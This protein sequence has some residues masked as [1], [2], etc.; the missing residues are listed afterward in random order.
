MCTER[1]VSCSAGFNN[2][3]LLCLRKK[4]NKSTHQPIRKQTN[5][6]NKQTKEPNKNPTNHPKNEPNQQTNQPSHAP[7]IEGK[8]LWAACGEYAFVAKQL[9]SVCSAESLQW[10]LQQDNFR[11]GLVCCINFNTCS[12]DLCRGKADC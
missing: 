2:E 8:A 9:A 5:K 6:P 7:T 11:L 1:G 10:I 4:L 3:C 12:G